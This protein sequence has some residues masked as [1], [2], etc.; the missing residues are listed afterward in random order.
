MQRTLFD[1][2]FPGLSDA[3]SDRPGDSL[4][5]VLTGISGTGK[6]MVLDEVEARVDPNVFV[7]R[8]TGNPLLK[9]IPLGLVS[10]IVPIDVDLSPIA[11]LASTRKALC[12]RPPTLFLVDDA[13]AADPL[14]LEILWDAVELGGHS[15]ALALEESERLPVRLFRLV[16][17]G[18]IHAHQLSPLGYEKLAAAA[19]EMLGAPL[20]PHVSERLWQR[21]EGRAAL[22]AVI[23]EDAVARGTISKERGTWVWSEGS[24]D[25]G[26][27]D[28]LLR[29]AI[30]SPLHN[31]SDGAVR[32]IELLSVAGRLPASPLIGEFG[33]ALQECEDRGV[34]SISGPTDRL[35]ASLSPP[36]IAEAVRADLDPLRKSIRSNEA[37]RLIESTT[38]LDVASALLAARLAIES[39][40]QKETVDYAGAA[41]LALSLGALELAERLARA[42]TWKAPLCVAPSSAVGLGLILA[43]AISAQGRGAESETIHERLASSVDD[44]DIY[45]LV[46]A[47]RAANLYW[48]CGDTETAHSTLQE[49]LRSDLSDAA[50]SRVLAARACMKSFDGDLEGSISDATEALSLD[51]DDFTTVWATSGAAFARAVRGGE[52]AIHEVDVLVRSGLDASRRC[53]AGTQPWLL[54]LA[55]VMAYCGEARFVEARRICD[56]LRSY[57]LGEPVTVGLSELLSGIIDS[58]R[59][60]LDEARGHAE[61]AWNLLKSTAPRG[62]ECVAAGLGAYVHALRGEPFDAR[63]LLNEAQQRFGP[64][65]AVFRPAFA[66]IEAHV[67]YACGDVSNAIAHIQRASHSAQA[68][69]SDLFML[70]AACGTVQ[71][72]QNTESRRLR[73]LIDTSL[74]LGD[75]LG[76]FAQGSRSSDPALLRDSSARFEAVD[77]GLLAAQAESRALAILVQRNSP[78]DVRA[79]AEIRIREICGRFAIPSTSPFVRIVRG[80]VL[81]TREHEVARQ[82]AA[83][84]TNRDIALM[85]GVSVRTVEGHVYRACQKL[86][87]SDR[88]ALADVMRG[89]SGSESQ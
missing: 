21:T 27:D 65:V 19:E 26:V 1:C 58:A 49:A 55:A 28:G 39:G 37:A 18:R 78:L 30:R 76:S 74:P 12:D 5:L 66:I 29:L 14:S 56:E 2:M 36:L 86:A 72:G 25:V 87:V 32:I 13:D 33:D 6:T 43:A 81:T 10:T 84:T 40:I 83:G 23:I 52:G 16:A 69:A 22:A 42:E 15:M 89:G 34:V 82:I 41:Q 70:A 38:P 44:A 24:R 64:Y 61:A 8:L 53:A 57:G 48:A 77:A 47:S 11:M 35:S 54:G 62:W 71:F 4:A 7:V 73:G 88:Y 80:V 20:A 50:R 67:A 75:A 85:L 79:A 68:V 45:A 31:L 59:G 17:S 3:L 46:A 63:E 51:H 60:Q 9:D